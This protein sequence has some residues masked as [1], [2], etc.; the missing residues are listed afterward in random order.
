ML[1]AMRDAVLGL[2]KIVEN[3][4]SFARK[5]DAVVSSHDPVQLVENP[6]P[7]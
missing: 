4:L 3:M 1:G 6:N 2:S 5:G 7:L